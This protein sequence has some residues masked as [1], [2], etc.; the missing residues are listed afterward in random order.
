MGV[1]KELPKKDSERSLA[2]GTGPA[3]ESIVCQTI[4]EPG[5]RYIPKN[6]WYCPGEFA[7]VLVQP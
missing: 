7:S 1:Q 3:S 4:G 5:D 6:S 2:T